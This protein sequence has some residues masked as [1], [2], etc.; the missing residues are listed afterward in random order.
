MK[1]ELETL[2]TSLQG[3]ASLEDLRAIAAQL[4]QPFGVRHVVYRWVNADGERY[5]AGTYSS[6]W[7][8]RYLAMDY[9]RVD[10]VILG[11]FQRFTPVDWK[12][13]DWSS[14]PARAMLRDARDHGIGNQGYSVPLRGPQG[15]F[16]LFTVNGMADDDEWAA[17]IEAQG[18]DLVLFAHEFNRKALD[19]AG[20]E[21]G[22]P[23]ALSPRELAAVRCLARGLSRAQI[24]AELGISEHT[25]RVYIESARH[26]LGALNT[27]HAVARAL[28]SGLIIV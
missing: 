22:R 20:G 18:R 9:L 1:A 8:D 27:T 11:C 28:S 26:K 17:L 6:A 25:L 5:R 15:Q 24:A 19:F 21:A 16:A 4:R 14:R 3:A 2:L 10:P 7:A 12:A 23:L 13:L